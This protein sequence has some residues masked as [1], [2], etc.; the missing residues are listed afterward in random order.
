MAETKKRIEWLDCARGLAMLL[1]I[2]GHVVGNEYSLSGYVLRGL[3][4]SLHIPLFFILSGL[5]F[6]PTAV[7]ADIRPRAVRS[8]E[9]LLLPVLPVYLVWILSALLNDQ[10]L[11]G[12]VGYWAR[13]FYTLLYASA[14]G[15]SFGR[16]TAES[17]GA[18][19]FL[20]VLFGMRLTADVL[21]VKIEERSRGLWVA[22]LCLVGLCMGKTGLYLPFSFDIALA[23][24]PF[25]WLG[26]LCRGRDI[27][28]PWKTLIFSCALWLLLT[29][30]SFPDPEERTYLELAVRRYSLF[31]LSFVGGA[32]GSLFVC[33]FSKLLCQAKRLAAPFSFLGR[34]SLELL[35]AH[36]LDGVIKPFWYMEGH[37]YRTA[38]LR[39]VVDLLLLAAILLGKRLLGKRCHTQS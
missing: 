30:L 11:A 39:I 1:V 2:I 24:L 38:L 14:N 8:A 31:P 7:E 23:S 36:A 17:I 19:W 10:S 32:A 27:A 28:H 15:Y 18:L 37:Q 3:I 4:F 35:C 13:R 21:T 20:F 5:V 12:N 22:V 16:A 9:R 26:L 29:A 33:A 34:N 25:F 6:K